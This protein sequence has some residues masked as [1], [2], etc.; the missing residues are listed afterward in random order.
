M[1]GWSVR[2]KNKLQQLIKGEN[3]VKY[4][5]AHRIKWGNILRE[6]KT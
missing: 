6:W 1:E 3:N 5:K 2:S 4:V